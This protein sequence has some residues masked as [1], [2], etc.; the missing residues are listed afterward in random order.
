MPTQPNL[1]VITFNSQTLNP[2]TNTSLSTSH[3]VRQAL[4]EYGCFVVSTN[5]IPWDL[6]EIMFELSKDLFY[7]PLETKIKNTSRI[8]G[9]GYG[10]HSS[11]P[12]YE[13]FGIEN[14]ATLEATRSFTHLLFP[15]GN[16]AF[17]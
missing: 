11:L 9:F 7:L 1:P 14:G 15:S 8:L 3:A 4:E 13:C 10:N 12:L 6:R 5:E 17:W 2:N 16:Q